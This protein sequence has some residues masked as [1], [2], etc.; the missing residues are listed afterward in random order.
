V[1]EVCGNVL[2]K[3]QAELDGSGSDGAAWLAAAG[4]SVGIPEG[5]A[6]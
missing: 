5:T 3:G 1:P 6:P 4:T 2:G